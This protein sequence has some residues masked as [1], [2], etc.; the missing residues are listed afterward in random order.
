M[1]LGSAH[2]SL[3]VEAIANQSLVGGGGVWQ[4]Q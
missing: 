3:E 2:E 4:L 1:L